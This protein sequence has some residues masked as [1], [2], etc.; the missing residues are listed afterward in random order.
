MGLLSSFFRKKKDEEDLPSIDLSKYIKADMH[1]HILPGI[2]DGARDLDTSIELIEGLV[3]LGF[4]QLLCTPHVMTDFYRNSTDTIKKNLYLLRNELDKRNINIHIDASAEYYFDEELVKRLK[5]RDILSFGK[6]NYLLF[7][8]SY[9]N[10]HQR[11][12]E[13]ITDMIELGYIPVLAHPE[14]Y[15]YYVMNQEK[16]DQIKSM[17]VKFQINLLSLSGNYGE[18]AFRGSKYLIDNHFVDF[19]GT[20]IHKKEHLVDLKKVLKNEHLHTLINSNNLLNSS[21]LE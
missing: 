5:N 18:S 13:I 11:I 20:D 3:Q 19:I 8:F 21:L 12:F 10:E 16:F 2:D 14:R 6:E 4:S 1:S 17:G 7:E 9:Y 15:P